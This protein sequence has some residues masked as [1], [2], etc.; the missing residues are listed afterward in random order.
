MK[1]KFANTR[2]RA[3]LVAG[4]L[5]S[6]ALAASADTLVTFRVD[7]SVAIGNASFNPLTQT[8]AA[9]GSFS[10]WNPLPLTNNPAGPN[11]ALYTGT[12][13]VVG[14]NGTVLQYKYTIEPG[15]VYEP[16]ALGGNHNRLVTLPAGGGSLATPV[17]YYGDAPPAPSTV[18]VTFQ[19]NMA[20]QINVGAF[21]PN[22][23]L[24]YTRGSFNNYAADVAM[25]NDPS[26]HTTN[27]FGL[28]SSNV[29]LA[30]Y[31]I[32][33]SP[34]QTVD[35]KY[36]FD[37]G[38]NWESP[39]PGVGDP[40][41]NNNR[42]F[43]LSATGQTNPIIYFND[44]PYAPVATNA[45][46]FQVDM[47]AHVLNGTFDPNT[48]TVEVR[49]NFNSWGTTPPILATNNP[50]AANTNIYSAV[51]PITDG[52][53]A[54]EF[55]KFWA[56]VPVN[57]GWETMNDNRSMQV[58]SG[59]TQTLPLVY[60]S[61]LTPGDLLP[62]QT[63]VT[64]RVN[65]T[66]AV[67]TD[68]HAFD[69]T[70]DGVYINGIQINNNSYS[71]TSWDTF[72]PQLTNNPIGSKIYTLDVL[73]P[74]GAPVQLTYKYSINGFD[75]E[76]GPNVNHVRYIRNTGTYVLPLDKFGNQLIDNEQSFGN[77][78]ATPSTAAHALVSWLGRPGVHLQT[79]TSLSAGSWVD[80]PE[81]DALS[82][83]NWPTGGGTLF[84]RLI[85]PNVP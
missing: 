59:T 69:S 20:Q 75:N 2:V 6:G 78:Q 72:L 66:N 73:I 37:P 64:F 18:P 52:V 48:G 39:G 65:M 68:A 44:A 12:T 74:K 33:G 30:T 46:T 51:F 61:N 82:S 54:T 26:I 55:Y 40:Q 10:N 47:T 36:F 49:G 70:T 35:F 7:M 50:A 80:H 84:F 29:Y 71:F 5:L 22:T 27:Q 77:L 67:G 15:A 43:N 83:T 41:D 45:V 13:N 42:F 4:L 57:T 62:A 1:A 76:A 9:R 17:V 58:V 14:G 23:S 24:V 81:T 63:T 60:F 79:R 25:T 16:V 21:N 38:A 3:S 32:I 85:K 56:S 28:V 8:V 34:G 31:S 53:G 11:P 19:V